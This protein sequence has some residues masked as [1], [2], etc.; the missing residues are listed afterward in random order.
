MPELRAGVHRVGESTAP[1]LGPLGQ[2]PQMPGPAPRPHPTE[3]IT[4][5]VCAEPRL[6][7]VAQRY[8]RCPTHALV[9]RRRRHES[10]RAWRALRQAVP[11]RAA[12]RCE[13]CGGAAVDAHHVRP[14]AAGGPD[15]PANLVALCEGCHAQ[16]HRS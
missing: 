10:T 5:T 9:E 7:E 15:T 11:D 4:P 12:G 13:A 3:M 16:E 2:L 1:W 6:P 8:G 14:R